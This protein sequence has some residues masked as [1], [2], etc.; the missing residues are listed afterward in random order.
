MSVVTLST[1]SHN[2]N[3]KVIEKGLHVFSIS[4]KDKSGKEHEI[5][6]GP[7]TPED[8]VK[9]RRFLH[10]LI[11]RYCNRLPHS[12]LT[13]PAGTKFTPDAFPNPQ[14][15]LHGGPPEAGW[16]Q[17]TL[18]RLSPEQVTLFS[19]AEVEALKSQFGEEGA[20]VWAYE[21]PDGEGGHVGKVRAEVA[22]GVRDAPKQDAVG[23]VVLVYRAKLLE[24]DETALN[25]TQ[26]WAFNLE[27][28][29]NARN[30][31]GPQTDIKQH[32]YQLNSTQCLELASDTALPTGHLID[33][34]K[35]RDGACNFKS[36]KKIGEPYPK[37]GLDDFSVFER[38]LKPAESKV[39]VDGDV[40]Q[41]GNVFG[42]DVDGQL[43]ETVAKLSSE[44][45]GLSLEF[46][47]NQS[48]VQYWS[49]HGGY[50]GS[51]ARRRVHGGKAEAGVG[52]GYNEPPALAMEFHEIYGAW[53]HPELK[54]IGWDTVLK[55][56]QVYNNWVKMTIKST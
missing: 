8:M 12:E 45:T 3:L 17:K 50:D 32:T 51:D 39:V 42:G 55:K 26:H 13:L 41:V 24:G 43:G 19:K 54:E 52:D 20:G 28:S 36:P 10:S 15:S 37:N 29:E 35:W 23:E 11:G 25:L 34:A 5:I 31:P 40:E 56:N 9:D 6:I 30:G 38:R 47:T 46:Q 53:M 33:A 21:S 48:G 14:T 7:E 4:F 27:A 16:D 1:K 44:K 49:G 22:I 2:L 18:E